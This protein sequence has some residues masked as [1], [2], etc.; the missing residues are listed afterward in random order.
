MILVRGSNGK[1]MSQ[2]R[3]DVGRVDGGGE[4]DD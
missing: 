3:G 2:G 4:G 1:F